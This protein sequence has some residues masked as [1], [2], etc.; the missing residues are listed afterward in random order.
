[1]ISAGTMVGEVLTLARLAVS[2]VLWAGEMRFHPPAQYAS[3]EGLIVEI[4]GD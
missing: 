1:M 4:A 3:A 2:D